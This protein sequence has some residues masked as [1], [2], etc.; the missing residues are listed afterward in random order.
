MSFCLCLG[1]ATRP[2]KNVRFIAFGCYSGQTL[3]SKLNKH[4]EHNSR[5]A[6]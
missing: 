1:C 2:K 3:F 4:H 6:L 5:T